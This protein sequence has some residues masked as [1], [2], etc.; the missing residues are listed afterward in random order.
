KQLEE[1][2]KIRFAIP[3]QLPPQL[4]IRVISDRWIGAEAFLSVSLNHLVLPENYQ[5]HTELLSLPP[6]P[7]TALKNNH[8]KRYVLRN[9]LISTLYRLRWAFRGHPRPKFN[10][11]RLVELT[12]DVTP[13]FRSTKNADIIRSYIQA[14]S[15]VIIDEIHLLGGN[16]EPILEGGL[17]NFSNLVRLVPLEIHIVGFSKRHYCPRMATMNKPTFINIMRHSPKSL[18]TEEEL[19]TI[20]SQI[21]DS[22]AV[23]PQFDD[24]ESSLHIQL[25]IH[26][27]AEIV[28]GTIK[29]RKEAMIYLSYPYLYRRL[30]QNP[31]YYE[32]KDAYSKTINDYLSN[33]FEKSMQ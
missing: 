8:L 17:F 18:M 29:S 16:R 27:N 32:L 20:Q 31:T 23:R 5:Q 28:A 13:D 6:L 15:L 9:L 12:G 2:Q 4:Y 30:Q 1:T 21:K 14:V 10:K 24:S 25:E 22:R 26:F 11:K 3:I 33:L 19:Q 7:V